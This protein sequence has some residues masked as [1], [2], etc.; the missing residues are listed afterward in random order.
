MLLNVKTEAI[1]YFNSA[2]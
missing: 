1:Y 2:A